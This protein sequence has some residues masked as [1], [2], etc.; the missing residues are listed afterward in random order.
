MGKSTRAPFAESITPVSVTSLVK[1]LVSSKWQTTVDDSGMSKMMVQSFSLPHV[2]VPSL[3]C[4]ASDVS[5]A[6]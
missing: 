6:P 1:S 4:S 3:V 2:K 5:S